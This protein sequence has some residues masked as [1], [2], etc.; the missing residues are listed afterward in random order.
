DKGE[1]L[2]L[3]TEYFD[4]APTI[5]KLRPLAIIVPHAGII[6]SGGV[7]AAGYKQIDR[8]SVFKHV[9]IIGSSHTMYFEGVSAY[10][11]GDFIT[12]MGKVVV[13]TLAGWLVKKY[14]F[15]SN[16]TRPHNGE[17]CLEVQLP[18]LQY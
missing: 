9:F 17:H 16:D 3:I 14:R 7:A 11:I 4:K 12:P 15:I 13:D 10:S 6:F 8:N 5:L 2:R 18:F 1:L